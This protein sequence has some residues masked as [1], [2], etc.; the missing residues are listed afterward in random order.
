M[1]Q[2]GIRG[3]VSTISNRYGCANNKYM[4]NDYDKS[5]EATSIIYLDANNLYG[6]AMSRAL[7]TGNFNWMSEDELA[8]WKNISAK[9]GTGCILEVD[10]EYPDGLHDLH[11]DYPLAPE[12]IIP[13]GSKVKK[14]IPNLN[15]KTKYVLHYEN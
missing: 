14:L 11:S 8:D 12:N 1:I 6:C 5:K 15:N 2:Q 4:G 7:P 10:L 9:D 13:A 3:G